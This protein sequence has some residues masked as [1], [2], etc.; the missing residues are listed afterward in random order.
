MLADNPAAAGAHG[1]GGQDVFIVLNGQDLAADQPCHADPVQQ[2]EDGEHGQHV[3]PDAGQDGALKALAQ[4][5]IQHHGEQ[6]H[7]QGIRK[8]VDNIHDAHH[9]QV[10]L[11]SGIAGDGPVEQADEQH[12]QRGEE[13]D[14]QGD[15]GTVNNA[16]KIVTA[17]F[18]RPEDVGEDVLA[19]VNGLLLQ[20]GI[21]EG[22]QVFGAFVPLA[23]DGDHIAVGIR[24]DQ[25]RDDDGD[26]NDDQHDHGS[27]GQGIA[28]KLAH[29]VPEEGGALAHHILLGLFLIRGRLEFGRI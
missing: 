15:A 11:P 3:R 2:A 12:D 25:R 29:T 16:H 7:H 4:Q 22:G 21:G 18:I 13:A 24:D 27:D 28:E 8:G 9:D 26:Q 14:S 23:V 20:L 6:D 1:P 19:L 5:L 10:R 17:E